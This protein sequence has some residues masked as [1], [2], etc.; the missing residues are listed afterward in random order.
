MG[1]F[2]SKGLLEGCLQVKGYCGI[3][4]LFGLFS[5]SVFGDS[6]SIKEYED[7]FAKYISIDNP[8]YVAQ[9]QR[10]IAARSDC[11]LWWE[12]NQIFRLLL[13]HF[14]RIFILTLVSNVLFTIVFIM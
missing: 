10:T 8:A 4:K 5:T 6:W 2:G 9:V 7:S 3:D 14:T 11:M 1:R 13:Y 12:A